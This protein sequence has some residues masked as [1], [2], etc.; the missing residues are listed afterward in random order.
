MEHG[1]SGKPVSDVGC[2]VMR[3]MDEISIVRT[4]IQNNTPL[5]L[6]EVVEMCD[7]TQYDEYYSGRA[8]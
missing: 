5:D 1:Q 3:T 6:E 7:F 2:D 4:P 8:Q